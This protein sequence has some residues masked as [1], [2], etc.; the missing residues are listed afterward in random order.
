MTTIT[1]LLF[2]VAKSCKQIVQL[3]TYFH[4]W[5]SNAHGAS[6]QVQ[7]INLLITQIS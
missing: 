7:P 1:C 2:V 4:K 3:P 5:S 6:T